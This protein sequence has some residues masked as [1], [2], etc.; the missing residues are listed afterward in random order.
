M[1]FDLR[2]RGRRRAVRVIY[3]GLAVLL[4][5]GLVGFGV[6]TGFGGGGLFSAASS[7][8]GGSA[9]FSA[10][11]KKY[12]K[13]TSQQP[14][15]AAA[16]EGL[17]KALLQESGNYTQNGVSARGKQI[18]REASEA[19]QS[20]IALNPASPNQ[21]LAHEMLAVYSE[22][23]LNE[24]AQAVS[25]LQIVVA[26]Q[27]SSAAL[28]A[29]LAE[30]AYKAH[31]TRTGDLAAEKAVALAPTADKARIKSQLAEVRANPSGEKTY[32]TTTNGKTYAVKKSA[33]GTFTGTEIKTTPAPAA[34]SSSTSTA[35]K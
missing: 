23:G 26:S 16:W 4:G 14:R 18:F 8:E 28:Y 10:Q 27:P 21:L 13:L 34:S 31:N 12:R 7:N 35:K 29:Q 22:E 6:G 2:G 32:R 5:V 33:N 9:S 19:W 17:T 1:L 11:I 3:I 20:Y 15:D 30:Y 25:V 24:P